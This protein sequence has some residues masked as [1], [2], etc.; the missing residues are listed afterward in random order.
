MHGFVVCLRFP[1]H[2]GAADQ[3]ALKQ[4]FQSGSLP[5][6][7]MATDP[8]NSHDAPCAVRKT[9]PTFIGDPA[10]LRL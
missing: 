5:M 8:T 9:P 4:N 2:L 7:A 3:I 1:A 10:R 6:K